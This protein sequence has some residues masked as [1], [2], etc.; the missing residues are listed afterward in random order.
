M[1]I[2]LLKTYYV[3]V[4]LFLFRLTGKLP[5]INLSV[6]DGAWI[7]VIR[8]TLSMNLV[9]LCSPQTSTLT[10]PI[11]LSARRIFLRFQNSSYP[12]L[13]HY[14]YSFYLVLFIG[15]FCYCFLSL[16]DFKIVFCLSLLLLM[17]AIPK[18]I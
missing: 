2:L 16:Q 6:L 13:M 18:R 9:L 4:D 3:L 10:N 15:F 8:V 11:H 17:F 7:S 5:S 14:R 12:L 1:N